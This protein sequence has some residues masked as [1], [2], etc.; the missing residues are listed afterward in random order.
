[1]D[2]VDSLYLTKSKLCQIGT[3][4]NK[5]LDKKSVERLSSPTFSYI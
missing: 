3:W 1:M 4:K 5:E 2:I